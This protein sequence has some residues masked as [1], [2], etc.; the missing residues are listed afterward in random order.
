MSRWSLLPKEPKF[1]AFYQQQAENTVKMAQ[2]L[3]DMIYVWQNVKERTSVLA[4][5]EQ[6]GDAITH[7]IMTL[8][9]STFIT[10]FDREDI[11][12]L[13]YALDNI[14]DRIHAIADM[15]YL[16]GIE[17]PTDRAK[18]LCDIIQIAVLEVQGGVSEMSSRTR[19][20]E[21]LK[22]CVTI[23]QIE[24]SGDRIYR[25][26][27][28]ELFAQPNDMATLVKWREVYQKM[29]STIDGCE[30]FADIMEGIALKY[31]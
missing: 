28:A 30:D 5:M 29:E 31:G 16:Y 13:A 9:N 10:P 11:S 21:L 2:Q 3:K 8:L 19:K 15:L 18:E 24:N 4:D 26:A 22:R 6:D 23:N 14:A 25:S 17:G 7:D 27:L 20:R 1:F 12:A